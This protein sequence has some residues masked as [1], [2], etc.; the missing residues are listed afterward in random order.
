MKW[1]LYVVIY[2][3]G[4]SRSLDLAT[5]ADPFACE[6]QA[7]IYQEKLLRNGFQLL[8]QPLCAQIPEEE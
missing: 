5:Y 2:I 7:A 8:D 6:N 3:D 1:L 4:T